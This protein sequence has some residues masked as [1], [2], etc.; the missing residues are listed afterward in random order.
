MNGPYRVEVTSR[1]TN[2]KHHTRKIVD[3]ANHSDKTWLTRHQHWAITN[4]LTVI[5]VPIDNLRALNS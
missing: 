4:G 3:Y 5:V 1:D 2:G